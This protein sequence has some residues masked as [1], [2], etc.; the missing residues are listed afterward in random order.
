[1]QLSKGIFLLIC[2]APH[3][4]LGQISLGV[5]AVCPPSVQS[6]LALQN[7]ELMIRSIGLE[8]F[9]DV[10]IIGEDCARAKPR[11]APV[12]TATVRRGGGAAN[13]P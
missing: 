1:M 2:K 5:R 4:R 12:G 8:D 10:V 3:A 9:F 6:P 13:T 7:A 11:A